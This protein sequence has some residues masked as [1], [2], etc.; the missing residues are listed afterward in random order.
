MHTRFLGILV[1][2]WLAV[3]VGMPLF[4]YLTVLLNRLLSP[5]V[6][7]LRRRLYKKA[8]LPDPD[9]LPAP[10]RLLLLALALRWIVFTSDCRC[11]HG[12][13]CSASRWLSPSR[14]ASGCSFC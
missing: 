3:L 12:K 6:G 9:F 10:V 8:D 13:S 11:W 7:P 5:L 2:N 1:I 14:P 4:Y